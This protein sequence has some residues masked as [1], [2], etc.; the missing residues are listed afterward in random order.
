MDQSA[1]LRIFY[2]RYL[3]K[4]ASVKNPAV[5]RAFATVPRELFVGPPPWHVFV[6]TDRSYLATPDDDL[7]FLYSDNLIALDPDRGINNGQPS[8][9][10][11]CIDSLS[12]AP[13]ETVLHIGSGT[14]Y[15]SAILANITGPTGQVHAF[16]TDPGLGARAKRNLADW[17]Q[18]VVHV[19]S[20]TSSPL[21]RADV[22]YVN[23]GAP[24][25]D[26]AW[27]D[28]LLPGGRLL[29]PL[30][31]GREG[32]VML[33]LQKPVH[34]DRWTAKFLLRV[35]FIPCEDVAR[36]SEMERMLKA[37]FDG[38][39]LQKV[40]YFYRGDTPGETCWFKGDGWWLSKEE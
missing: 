4:L 38:D 31:P 12:I 19:R 36:A 15:Y 13:G 33:L 2:A 16:E 9:H 39:D 14:G 28:A 17:P 20:G 23:A 37:A 25:P 40:K 29:F 6:T 18:V 7:M 34:G 26:A 32:G 11:Y 24:E 30:Q 5:E 8:L 27:L 10:A 3:S 1:K 35:H 22:I 21:P